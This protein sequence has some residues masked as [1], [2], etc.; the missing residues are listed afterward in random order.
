METTKNILFVTG[1]FVTHH[2]W[3]EWKTYFEKKGYHTV[4]PPAF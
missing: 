2:C 3:D 1:A 4:A